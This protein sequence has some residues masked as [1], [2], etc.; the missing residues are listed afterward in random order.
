M[1]P[2]FVTGFPGFIGSELVARLLGRYPVDV[3]IA[4]LVQES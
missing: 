4:C 1:S 3:H 2:V